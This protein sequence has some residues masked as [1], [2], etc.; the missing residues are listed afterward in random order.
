MKHT[1]TESCKKIPDV[2]F[3]IAIYADCFGSC[4]K[5]LDDIIVKI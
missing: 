3:G 2:V 1:I 4:F 5:D